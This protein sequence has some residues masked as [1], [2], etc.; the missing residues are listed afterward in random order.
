MADKLLLELT[1]E[2]SRLVWHLVAEARQVTL[3][4]APFS[5]AVIPVT[6]LKSAETSTPDIQKLRKSIREKI[7]AAAK[8]A[9]IDSGW[10][11]SPGEL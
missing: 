9:Q 7:K 11:R 5:G 10:W 8:D 2:E 1:E 3:P 4:T 6:A